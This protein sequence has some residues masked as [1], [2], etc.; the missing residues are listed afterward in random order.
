MFYVL[1]CHREGCYLILHSVESLNSF[2][3]DTSDKCN[4]MLTPAAHGTTQRRSDTMLTP[5][6]HGTTQRRTDTML[7]PAGHGTTQQRT[8]TMLTPAGHGTTQR[9]TDTSHL[10]YQR[11]IYCTRPFQQLL[12]IILCIYIYA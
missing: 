11:I 6:A 8:D 12:F 9:R 10:Y 2:T 4:D 3:H 1:L 7:T 5:A